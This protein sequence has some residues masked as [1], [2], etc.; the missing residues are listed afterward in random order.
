MQKLISALFEEVTDIQI[1]EKDILTHQAETDAHQAEL[2]KIVHETEE[3]T[4]EIA[5]KQVETVQ[6]TTALG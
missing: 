2:D 5:T 1:H 6:M 3:R 4:A